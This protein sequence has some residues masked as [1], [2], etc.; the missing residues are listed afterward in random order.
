MVGKQFFAFSA[1]L[2]MADFETAPFPLRAT[3]P[4][5]PLGLEVLD[6]AA[7]SSWQ[8]IITYS[9]NRKV[10]LSF[11]LFDLMNQIFSIKN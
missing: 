8:W 11:E 7:S 1:N 5:N 9:I 4:C 6:G 3:N 10:S 2:V